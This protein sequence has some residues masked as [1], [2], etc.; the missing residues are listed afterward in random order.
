MTI[1]WGLTKRNDQSV[2]ESEYHLQDYNSEANGPWWCP[3][4]ERIILFNWFFN[5][6]DE[7][8][9]RIGLKHLKQ[10]V[11]Q[12]AQI[13]KLL[14][15]NSLS[16]ASQSLRLEMSQNTSVSDPVVNESFLQQ[17][18][19]WGN[20]STRT[21]ELMRCWCVH[22]WTEHVFMVSLCLCKKK[23]SLFTLYALDM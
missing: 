23:T 14:D 19:N 2:Q 17:S 6:L 1:Y 4:H 7:S 5:E 11:A 21:E 10:F 20:S 12:A 15:Q 9:H 22:V 3:V 16:D 8:V 13:Y 18:L